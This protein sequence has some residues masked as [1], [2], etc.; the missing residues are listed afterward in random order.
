[1]LAFFPKIKYVCP[2]SKSMLRIFLFFCFVFSLLAQTEFPTYA[3]AIAKGT[4]VA[5]EF[6]SLS[7]FEFNPAS[8]HKIPYVSLAASGT[9]PFL[10]DQANHGSLFAAIPIKEKFILGT[11]IKMF[12][13]SKL[14][15]MDFNLT[16]SQQILPK[17]SFA[18]Q[19][20]YYNLNIENFQT[21]SAIYLNAGMFY[22]LKHGFTFG[23]YGKNL[24]AAKI[25]TN[26]TR[27]LPMILGMGIGYKPSEQVFLNLDLEKNVFFPVNIKFGISYQPHKDFT[28]LLGGQTAPS[29]VSAGFRLKLNKILITVATAYYSGRLGIS[30]VMS[31][32]FI[33]FSQKET[34]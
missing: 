33:N 21:Y 31:A 12:S 30:P 3:P 13:V 20:H 2:N 32:D 16:Y 29:S 14:Q 4:A 25:E 24:N 23:A 28:V 17:V 9:K 34:E 18:L 15:E 6:Q 11:G 1:M 27:P 10:L 8:L 26:N 19:G 22:E 7:A 5:G